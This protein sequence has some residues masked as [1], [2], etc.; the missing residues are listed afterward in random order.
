MLSNPLLPDQA[1]LL[2][3]LF[4]EEARERGSPVSLDQGGTPA[5]A[6]N[7]CRGPGAVLTAVKPF[8]G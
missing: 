7:Q 3:S 4:H 2:K 6:I 8:S 1:F 5:P